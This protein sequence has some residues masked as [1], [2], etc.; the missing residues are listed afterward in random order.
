MAIMKNGTPTGFQDRNGKDIK[1]A[2][3]IKHVSDGSILTIDKF[4]KAVSP[5]GFKYEL[6]SMNVSRGMNPD[7]T[8]FAHLTDYELT[9][10][11]PFRP[12]GETVRPGDDSENMAPERVRDPRNE[13]LL[14]KNRKK[15]A[16]K[17]DVTPA[18]AIRILTI[19]DF[20]DDELAE[21]LQARGW[22]GSIQKV[23]TIQI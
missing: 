9:E 12:E 21:E 10:E 6:T 13:K 17:D 18:E 14:K 23:R 11:V 20:A 5:L 19:Q 7:G 8:Y 15:K 1:T 4:G 16:E 2:D 22:H 3:R